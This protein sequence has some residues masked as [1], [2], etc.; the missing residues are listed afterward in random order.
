[1]AKVVKCRHQVCV[2]GPQRQAVGD[3][4]KTGGSSWRAASTWKSRSGMLVATR[5]TCLTAYSGGRPLNGD[6]LGAQKSSA[7]AG[8]A[9]VA[10]HAQARPAAEPGRLETERQAEAF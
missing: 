2:D 8:G 7:G 1:M 5:C 6:A 4:L 10:I 9:V 3:D